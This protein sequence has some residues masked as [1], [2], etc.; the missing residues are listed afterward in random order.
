M[1]VFDRT[2]A[3]FDLTLLTARS[4]VSCPPLRHRL[5][6]TLLAASTRLPPRDFDVVREMFVLACSLSAACSI[7]RTSRDEL[8][9]AQQQL[10][11]RLTGGAVSE[12][13]SV[14]HVGTV[15]SFHLADSVLPSGAPV[16]LCTAASAGLCGGAGEQSQSARAACR[17]AGCEPVSHVAAAQR[18]SS[19]RSWPPGAGSRSGDGAPATPA[20]APSS[21]LARTVAPL[22]QP[23]A[24]TAGS[25]STG[26]C[27][28]RV[29]R[30]R[31]ERWRARRVWRRG[32]PRRGESDGGYE[33]A[34]QGCGS[35]RL[36]QRRLQ[37][38]ERSQK[39]RVQL[40]GACGCGPRVRAQILQGVSETP[41]ARQTPDMPGAIFRHIELQS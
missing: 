30:R 11:A 24:A 7:L 9:S 4:S 17:L 16:R 10:L 33:S 39:G 8:S 32:V 41:G 15:L 36:C 5:M 37:G 18:R 6:E 20:L 23:A 34:R 2:V 21:L 3:A 29:Q 31:L 27:C 38:A 1:R 14:C 28:P 26:A 40:R 25:T 22:R 35:C 12:Q 13:A 19:C